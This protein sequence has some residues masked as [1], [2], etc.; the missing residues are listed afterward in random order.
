MHSPLPTFVPQKVCL[1]CD[2]CCRFK[3]ETSI[4]RPKVAEEEKKKLASYR[5][6]LA[7]KIFSK[8][9]W[10]NHG[11]IKAVKSQ[12]IC[13]CHFFNPQDNTCRV[14]PYRPWE[15]QLYP[16]LLTKQGSSLV[17]C[18]HLACPYVQEYYQTDKFK[19]YAVQLE[20]YFKE[21]DVLEFIRN[22]PSLTGDYSAYREELEQVFSLRI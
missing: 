8:T 9:P 4:F 12:G 16:F 15:C 2:G 7:Q 10:D 3:E 19:D 1:A 13:H 11:F 20:N 5:S 14:Y 6:G 22:N 17:I 18:V 21:K